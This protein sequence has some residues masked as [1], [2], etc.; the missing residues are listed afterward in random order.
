MSPPFKNCPYF[1]IL[2][3]THTHKLVSKKSFK[4]EKPLFWS[5]KDLLHKGLVLPGPLTLIFKMYTNV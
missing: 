1:L 5:K 4:E 3:D 2:I